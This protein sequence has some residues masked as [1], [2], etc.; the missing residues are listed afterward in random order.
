MLFIQQIWLIDISWFSVTSNYGNNSQFNSCFKGHNGYDNNWKNISSKIGNV[1][2]SCDSLVSIQQVPTSQKRDL[3]TREVNI[4][5]SYWCYSL[6]SLRV[7]VN[8]K[9]DK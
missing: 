5:H 4:N 7:K 3:R 8:R 6:L 9:I 1:G 2:E